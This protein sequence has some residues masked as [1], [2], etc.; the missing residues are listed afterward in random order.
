MSANQWNLLPYDR[1]MYNAMKTYKRL[2]YK[3]DHD[4]FSQ[5]LQNVQCPEMPKTTPIK[6]HPHE[7]LCLLKKCD[8]RGK[9][10][11]IWSEDYLKLVLRD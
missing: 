6:L 8:D 3:H 4:R 1:I 10:T 5:H 11:K 7:I 9:E 2:F